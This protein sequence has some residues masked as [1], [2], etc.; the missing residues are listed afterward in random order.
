MMRLSVRHERM[1]PFLTMY[2]HQLC[3]AHHLAG[4]PVRDDTSLVHQDNAVAHL[5]DEF[6]I[7]GGN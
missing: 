2:L 1:G 5:Q 3:V 6:Q 4:L 7:M